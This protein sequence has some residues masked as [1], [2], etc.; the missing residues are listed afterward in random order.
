MRRI[1]HQPHA[2]R[3]ALKVLAAEGLVTMKLRRGAYVTEGVGARPGRGLPPARA[4][5]ERC[6]ARAAASASAAEMAEL[7]A[8]HDELERTLDD[9]ERFFAANER[10]HTRLLE[11][12]D[13]RWR[14]QMVADLRKVMK[15]N[16]AQS[17]LNRAGWRPGFEH[18]QIMAA[19]EGVRNAERAATADAAASRSRARSGIGHLS[20]RPRL[21]QSRPCRTALASRSSPPSPVTASIGRGGELVWRERGPAAFPP[22]HPGLPG[23]HGPQ[24]LGFAAGAFPPCPAGATS[25]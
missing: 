18:R 3:E 5:G 16:R 22:R 2:L 19:A 9:R 23:D 20:L 13:N 7:L 1:R 24:D 10:F 6:G 21:R 14:I 4:A 12:A 11:I 17:L 8:I 25:S 15:L